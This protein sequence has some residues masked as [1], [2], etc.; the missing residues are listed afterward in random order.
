M[1]DDSTPSW[2]RRSFLKA[3]GAAGTAAA[4]G[5]TTVQAGRDPGPKENELLVGISASVETASAASSIERDT[6]SMAS[7]VHRNDRLR[8]VAVELPEAATQQARDRVYRQLQARDDVKYVE[9]NETLELHSFEPN[10][11]GFDQQY[12][13][14][15]VNAP[16]A[17]DE[18]GLGS[19]DVTI[20]IVDTGTDYEHENLADRFGA[21][22]GYDFAGGNSD[23]MPPTAGESHGTH[24][25]GIASAT[26]DNGTGTA[27]V[28]N[29]R[30][31][32]L[33][34]R[35]NFGGS[36][37]DIADSVQWA[38]DNGADLINM[39]LGGGGF[40][41][42]MKQAVSYA[43]DRDV[44]LLAS[45]GNSDRSPVEYPSR[46]DEVMSGSAIDS[47]ENLASFSS[48][49]EDLE[50]T[51]P[52]VD[53]L[54]TMPNDDYQRL[55]GTSM[56]CPAATGV[57]ALGLAANP[58]LSNDELRVALRE[59]ARDVGLPA[60]EQGSGCADAAALVAEVGDGDPGD[61]GD[62]EPEPGE[63]EAVIDASTTE[64]EVGETVDLDATG[65]SS[66]NG[67]IVEY[68]W[69]TSAGSVTGPTAQLTRDEETDV[70]VTLEVTDEA[71]ET[72]STT[73]TISFGGDGVGQCGEDGE[74]A[75]AQGSLSW[76][77][78]SDTYTYAPQT[79]DPC[80]MNVELDG[81]SNA[82]FDLYVTFD[83]RTPT[84]S[85]FDK[86]SDTQDAQEQVIVDDVDQVSEL[87]ILVQGV[88]GGGDY[89][90]SVEELTF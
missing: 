82:D 42:T 12:A 16:E 67:D 47:N 57:A 25:S 50:L 31:L 41:Q 74:F 40:N 69:S 75:S 61:P 32:S 15:Q 72:D 17:W 8:Y 11:P 90:V 49:G 4:V 66:E 44:L 20:A 5:V 77:N 26:T 36:T 62:P 7:V 22:K 73:E 19:D 53:V 88:S 55:S 89:T 83:G 39:S 2:G 13:P 70:D 14:Q 1:A 10:D 37:A 58:E 76:W 6:P 3:T 35:G 80:Q 59:T 30:L 78:P 9:E 84:T 51:G 87:G 81:P 86:K 52:G 60:N 27:G 65:S 71:G 33:R 68:A 28:S 21:E 79:A 34:A 54:S 18:I 64:P 24:V 45:A 63:I 29:S 48:F 43:Y 38:A 46:Y 56:S 85:D 23:P